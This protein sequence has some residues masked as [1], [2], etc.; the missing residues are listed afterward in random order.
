ML[1]VLDGVQSHCEG[2]S[3]RG[4]LQIG[5]LAGLGI[6]LP[7][8]LANRAQAATSGAANCILMRV[9]CT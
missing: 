3:R 5:A 7:V 1:T 8:A 6:S 9:S 2:V 4:F